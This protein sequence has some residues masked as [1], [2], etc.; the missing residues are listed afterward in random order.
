MER[1][2]ELDCCADVEQQDLSPFIEYCQSH[3]G[4]VAI[5]RESRPPDGSS[6]F[7]IQFGRY[8]HR[9]GKCGVTEDLEQVCCVVE[10]EY[11]IL[12]VSSDTVAN[13]FEPFPVRTPFAVCFCRVIIQS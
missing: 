13:R 3:G 12:C 4:S 1:G 7:G 8:A 6:L 11:Q 9:V 5:H 10:V 2:L